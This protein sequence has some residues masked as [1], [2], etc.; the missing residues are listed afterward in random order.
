[1]NGAVETLADESQAQSLL[2][3]F[4]ALDMKQFIVIDG[5]DELQEKTREQL[6][7]FL[8]SIVGECDFY[9]PGKVRIILIGVDSA[10]MQTALR[11]S[12]GNIAEY[13]ILL[14]R[15]QKDIEV[16]VKE[17]SAKLKDKHSLKPEQVTAAEN[18]ICRRSKGEQMSQSTDE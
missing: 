11:H 5:I 14:E 12:E 7:L 8:Q 1:M 4:C 17:K 9:D 18:M 6:L 13:R 3:S 2:K 15:V 16:F 10:D